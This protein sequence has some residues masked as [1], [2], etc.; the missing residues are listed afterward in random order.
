LRYAAKARLAGPGRHDGASL[1][2]TNGFEQYQLN[3]GE[4]AL[5]RARSSALDMVQ[6]AR[7]SEDR[8]DLDIRHHEGSVRIF[9]KPDSDDP[10]N[11]LL[12]MIDR[13]SLEQF[14]GNY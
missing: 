13:R 14:S 4:I 6:A 9:W 1:L 8:P 12:R 10:F 2:R 3:P 5:E 11:E 7:N